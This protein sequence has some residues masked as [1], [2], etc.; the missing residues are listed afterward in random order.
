[1]KKEGT[2]EAS[3]RRRTTKKNDEIGSL[4][5]PTRGT[6]TKRGAKRIEEMT[7][8]V[9]RATQKQTKKN[10]GDDSY[11]APQ[12]RTTTKRKVQT[13]GHINSQA[14]KTN[15]GKL[16]ADTY[17]T[18]QTRKNTKKKIENDVYIDKQSGKIKTKREKQEVEEK[19][20]QTRKPRTKREIGE[21]REKQN[22]RPRNKREL[23]E[24]ERQNKKEEKRRRKQ[25][26]K[27]RRK[28]SVAW[29]IFKILVILLILASISY[30]CYFAYR[31][32][33]NG[34]GLQGFMATAMG[35]DENTLKDLEPIHFML[36]G[37]S[38][39]EEYKLADTIMVCS[40]NPKTQKASIL[41]IPRDTYVG[42]DKTKA[43]ASY[44]INAVYRN[45][46]NVEGMVEHIE[47][48]T[49]LEIDNYLIIDT[50]ALVQLV[51][52]LG[53]V[54]F[55]VPIDMDYDDPTQDL[56]IHL[57]AGVQKLDGKQAEGLVRFRHSNDFSTYPSEY[58][59]ND[60]G[61]MRTQR[62]FITQVMKQTVRPE[63]LLKLVQ[64][65]E[66][67]FKNINTNMTFNTV[68][69]YL[70]YAVNFN[71]EDLKTG[72]LPGEAELANKVWIYTPNV[73]QIKSLV[74]ELFVEEREV[75]EDEN[76][77][78]TNTIGNTI[79][80]TSSK[81]ESKI[82]IELLNGSGNEKNLTKAVERLEQ[83]GYEIVKKGNTKTTTKTTIINRSNQDDKTSKKLKQDLKAG[84]ISK[85]YNN[86]QVDYT[87]TL[88]KD[89]K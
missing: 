60:I 42:K 83:K 52:A 9:Q 35:H 39:E 68:K 56:Y 50:K 44:K 31:V 17:S 19:R 38:G 47:N 79:T 29:K 45:G 6:R 8:Q 74:K 11:M 86:S 51:D 40:Y 62:E 69:D 33:K 59:D 14:R 37:I 28:K 5:S 2:E 3:N 36:V 76:E 75:E 20:E 64:I 21:M 78:N 65:A 30:G 54:T 22:Q 61:R 26:K 15:R 49:E 27:E 84:T 13:D 71:P 25:E 88:G 23:K 32:S 24:Q 18:S 53:G 55:D 82:K 12:R 58:G 67:G 81:E 41:S 89:Y 16:E 34:G 70:P 1:M 46:E 73:K 80:G 57:K 48:L 85:K 77:T 4:N 43:S 66:I 72:T 87:I 10:V 63:N 7:M